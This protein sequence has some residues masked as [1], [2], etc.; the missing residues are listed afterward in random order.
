[1]S[2]LQTNQSWGGRFTESTDAFVAAF[3]ASVDFDRRMYAQDESRGESGG[4][5]NG[6][7]GGRSEGRGEGRARSDSRGPRDDSASRAPRRDFSRPTPV[8]R[9]PFF[10]K[11][12]E[13]PKAADAAAM[14]SWEANAR[15][16]N[17]GISANIKPKRKIAALFKTE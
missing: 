14:P 15:P 16:V 1:M 17:R 11:P 3:T 4:G 13:E 10:D 7:S 12:Y 9:D 2:E 6:R 8:S 5:D